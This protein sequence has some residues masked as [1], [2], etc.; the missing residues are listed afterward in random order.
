MRVY[1]TVGA[2]VCGQVGRGI[3][4]DVAKHRQWQE[5]ERRSHRKR[6][7]LHGIIHIHQKLVSALEQ[8]ALTTAA[9]CHSATTVAM[10]S[11]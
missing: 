9:R 3:A 1:A 11:S 7:H 5:H 2:L 6:V 8:Q 10:L 4:K